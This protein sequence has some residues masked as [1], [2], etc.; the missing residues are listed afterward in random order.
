MGEKFFR[1]T[2]CYFGAQGPSSVL[3]S[4]IWRSCTPPKMASF[5][6]FSFFFSF[7][8]CVCV[9]GNPG[10]VLTS[11]WVQKEGVFFGKEGA[12]SHNLAYIHNLKLQ[13]KPFGVGLYK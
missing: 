10:E 13:P 3:Q 4:I 8:L 7:F 9:E 11:N 1:L 2:L 6:L 12:N 5:F